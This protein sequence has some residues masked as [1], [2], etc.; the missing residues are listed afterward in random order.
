MFPTNNFLLPAKVIA[1]LYKQRW[2]VELFFKWIKQNLRIKSFYGYSENAVRTQLWIAV[3][4]YCLLAIIKKQLGGDRELYEIQEVLSAS[5]FQKIPILQAFSNTEL[6]NEQPHPC[7]YL[8][9]FDL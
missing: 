5:I 3:T 9:L 1:E 6:K 2:Q 8:P 7:N 4:V